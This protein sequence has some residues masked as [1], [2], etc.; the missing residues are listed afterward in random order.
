MAFK[1]DY[2]IFLSDQHRADFIHCAGNS[3]VRTPFLD[4]LAAQGARFESAYTA[5]PF[6][7]PA[8][9]SMLSGQRAMRTQVYT[10]H[11][12]I[13]DD[14]ATFL[15]SLAA[16]GYETVL[17]GRMHFEGPNQRHGFT[18]RIFGDL[19]QLYPG[20]EDAYK[21]LSYYRPTIS[22]GGCAEIVGGGDH[23]PTLDY[24]RKVI[25]KALEYLSQDHDKP[26]CVV[27][28]TYAPHF[29]F[30]GPRELYRYY[31]E[32]LKGGD[33]GDPAYDYRLDLFSKRYHI[34]DRDKVLK[35]RAAYYAMVENMDQQIGQVYDAWQNFLSRRGTKGVFVY[36]SDH[37][38]ALGERDMYAKKT[39]YENAAGIPMIFSGEHVVPGV[40]CKTPV[41]LMDV[42]ITLCDLAGAEIPYQSDGISLKE[43]LT[44]QEDM[45][46]VTYSECIE[47]TDSG[48]APGIM[49]RRGD[50]KLIWYYGNDSEMLL[51]NLAE[52]P[53]ETHNLV[54]AY[55][56]K[57]EE[58]KALIMEVWNPE[59][60]IRDHT[61]RTAHIKLLL[62]WG[63]A[64][65]PEETERW[66]IPEEALA[67]PELS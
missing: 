34:Y 65:H 31:Y 53:R 36:T 20:Q 7:V 61:E 66:H 67:L 55:A 44:G 24:D 18:K 52:D 47:N 27:I 9:V 37:G 41:N 54:S 19:L 5:C 51:F 50:W 38:E 29:P 64:V 8:R 57:A 43:Q 10:N 59:Q 23:S 11:G 25:E 28:G 48:F 30:V 33:Q 35:M 60:I 46:R 63:R 42:G 40:R 4:K 45:E 2:L 14:T 22:E 12:A 39:L 15:H 16:E 56:E 32:K 3:L 58:L 21:E 17:C 1:D 13:R 6:C 26:Q 49:V 62:K